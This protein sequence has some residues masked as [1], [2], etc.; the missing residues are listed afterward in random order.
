MR[1]IIILI[2]SVILASSTH[3]QTSKP[4][5]LKIAEAID[6]IPVKRVHPEYPP[7]SARIGQ[8]GW[9]KVSFV[10]NQKGRVVDPVVLDSSGGRGFEREAIKALKKWRY[11]P[12][13]ENGQPVESCAN[14]VQ[15][16]F[17]LAEGRSGA[18]KKGLVKLKEIAGALD[19][20]RFDIA[21]TL[22]TDF[23]SNIGNGYE[24]SFYHFY[25]AKI[26]ASRK[27][28]AAQI[29]HLQGAIATYYDF[30]RHIRKF[31]VGDAG[32]SL[33][34]T[35]FALLVDEGRWAEAINLYKSLSFVSGSD[36]RTEIKQLASY[37]EKIDNFEGM[38]PVK[39]SL[40]ERAVVLHQLIRSQFAFT[41]LEGQIDGLEIRC[42]KRRETY[43]FAL[44]SQ[45]NIPESWGACSVLLKGQPGTKVTLVE[46]QDS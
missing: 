44:D 28:T 23:E 17:V 13:T 45:W 42:Q 38:V 35:A 25:A 20:D 36:E 33:G 40:D 27:D 19:Q 43:T 39:L 30:Q 11:E 37:V 12:A 18:T 10:V 26:A 15:L 6:P 21:A 16:D 32:F 4:T 41:S 29:T 24:Q 8:Q 14:K 31:Y 5:S 9:V 22:L 2:A 34:A 46:M 1:R 7:E 3:A